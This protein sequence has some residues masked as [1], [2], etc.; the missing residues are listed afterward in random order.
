MFNITI[1]Y[2]VGSCTW[3]GVPRGV[4]GML[5]NFTAFEERSPCISLSVF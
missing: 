3:V 4:G 1:K 5:G 2:D